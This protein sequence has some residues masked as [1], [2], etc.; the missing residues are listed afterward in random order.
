MK[1]SIVKLLIHELLEIDLNYH[2]GVVLER[3]ECG[4]SVW[5]SKYALWSFGITPSRTNRGL[6]AHIL[7]IFIPFLRW[8]I[9]SKIEVYPTMSRTKSVC[10]SEL[11]LTTSSLSSGQMDDVQFMTKKKCLNCIAGITRS[12]C[13]ETLREGIEGRFSHQALVVCRLGEA[14]CSACNSIERD[15]P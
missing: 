11:F 2:H 8:K 6:F 14:Y 3:F 15:S 1:L 7:P 4:P 12:I 13:H 10:D 9:S 5:A